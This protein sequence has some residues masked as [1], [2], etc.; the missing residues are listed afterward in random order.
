MSKFWDEGWVNLIIID[1][2]SYG[3]C[4]FGRVPPDSIH[5]LPID[6]SPHLLLSVLYPGVLTVV[7]VLPGIAPKMVMDDSAL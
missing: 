4:F 2:A 3:W 7:P 6:Q 1:Y 5:P